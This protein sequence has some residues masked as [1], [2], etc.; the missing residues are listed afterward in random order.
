[1]FDVISNPFSALMIGILAT[2]LVQSSSTSTSIISLVGAGELS[3]KNAISMIMGANIGTTITNTLV[4]HG[5]IKGQQSSHVH[6]LVQLF[7]TYL[8]FISYCILSSTVGNKFS[9]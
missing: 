5:H 8:I 6:L 3:V 2:V 9:R 4:A 7:M 1:M